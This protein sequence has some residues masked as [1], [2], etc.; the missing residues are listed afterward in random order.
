MNPRE[1][2][3]LEEDAWY[4][5]LREGTI[6]LP[7]ERC[8]SITM[9]IR[10]KSQAKGSKNWRAI[11]GH[12][13]ALRSRVAK[14]LQETPATAIVAHLGDRVKQVTFIRMAPR[15]LDDDN[16]AHACKPIRDQIVAWLAGDNRP[17][18]RADDGMRSGY[19]FVYRQQQ[20]RAYGLRVELA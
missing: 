5:H 4:W 2:V 3:Q 17:N 8:V 15:L 7:A 12:T 18:A 6:L 16:L 1:H 11:Y 20:Q 14:R 13:V 19:S 10:L 9:G